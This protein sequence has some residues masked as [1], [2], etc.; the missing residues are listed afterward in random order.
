[1][2]IFSLVRSLRIP[3]LCFLFAGFFLLLIPIIQI[4]SGCE[5]VV[6]ECYEEALPLGYLVMKPIFVASSLLLV[7]LGLIGSLWIYLKQRRKTLGL[8]AES[9]GVT[10]PK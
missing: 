9:S 10:Q 8:I 4:S 5:R 1:M 2:N 6:S 3:L 7:V